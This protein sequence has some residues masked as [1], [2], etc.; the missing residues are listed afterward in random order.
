M[1]Q[2]S[3]LH[4]DNEWSVIPFAGQGSDGDMIRINRVF[5]RLAKNM[6]NLPDPLQRRSNTKVC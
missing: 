2:T 1:C 4:L 5:L 3:D 6:K